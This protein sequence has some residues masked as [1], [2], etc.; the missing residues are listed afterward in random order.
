MYPINEAITMTINTWNQFLNYANR[1]NLGWHAE[2]QRIVRWPTTPGFP[3]TGIASGCT[4][5]VARRLPRKLFGR[6]MRCWLA[7]VDTNNGK[8]NT[9]PPGWKG[10]DEPWML[11]YI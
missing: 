8:V 11:N 4:A 9:F 1:E 10:S 3:T 7:T 5:T 6:A 2:A